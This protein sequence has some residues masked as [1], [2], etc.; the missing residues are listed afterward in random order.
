[1]IVDTMVLRMSM[2]PYDKRVVVDV[3]ALGQALQHKLQAAEPKQQATLEDSKSKNKSFA[4]LPNKRLH[5]IR[6][7]Q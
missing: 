6:D 4:A 3:L 2:K 1:M 5:S 7:C